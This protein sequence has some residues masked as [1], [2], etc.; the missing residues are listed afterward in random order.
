MN[1]ADGYVTDVRYPAFFYKEMQPLWLAT[2][3]G[4]Q[5]FA[6][7]D[8][9][10]DFAL[11]EMGCGPGTNLLV[12]AACHPQAR[13][14]GVDFN[15]A[16]IHTARQAATAIGLDNVTFVHADFASFAQQVDQAFDMITCHGAWSWIAD[17]DRGAILDVATRCLSPD[18]LLY[19]HYMCHPGS[20]DLAPLQK[21]LRLCAEHLPG[22]SVR[23][24]QTGMTLLDQI[25]GSGGFAGQPAM[26]RHL[27][28]MARRD[29]A[30]LAH[31][32]LTDHWQPQHSVD[33]HRQVGDAGLRYI[34]SADVFNNLDVSLSIPGQM[35]PLIRRTAVPALAEAMKDIARNAHQRMDLFQKEP[36]SLGHGA[37]AAMRFRALPGELPKGPVKFDTS[38]G[39]ITG[40]EAI[41]SPLL[42]MLARGPASVGELARL[43]AFAGDAAGVIQSLQL[44]MMCGIAHP[45]TVSAPDVPDRVE[46]LAR[47]FG[48]NA[49]PFQPIADGATAIARS[50][51]G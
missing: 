29:P 34:C 4:F 28:N 46:R 36:R 10:A 11:C 49:I 27:A 35:Q 20:T 18:G 51:T 43:P 5:G 40:P 42:A 15:V 6:A 3:A 24:A 37:L 31:E 48:E 17:A 1:P 39:A 16:H 44:L 12:S 7:P 47:W 19:L 23:Q 2:V 45:V 41:F 33:L 8:L 50:A 25:A 26:H 14:V 30:D 22:P 21:M 13:F 32:F 38:I 9:A